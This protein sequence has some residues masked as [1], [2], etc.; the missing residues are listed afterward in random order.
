M[1]KQAAMNQELFKQNQNRVFQKTLKINA[2]DLFCL[3]PFTSSNTCWTACKS[4]VCLLR[5]IYVYALWSFPSSPSFP[6]LYIASLN[7]LPL[8]VSPSLSVSLIEIVAPSFSQQVILWQTLWS[9]FWQQSVL[10]DRCLPNLHSR[11]GN[12]NIT[13][14]TSSSRLDSSTPRN[15]TR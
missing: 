2:F 1:S 8:A 7:S 9:R 3:C 6:Y 10:L 15:L 12:S 13:W 4:V 14:Q 5:E 11:P